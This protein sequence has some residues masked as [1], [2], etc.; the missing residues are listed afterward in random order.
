MSA[1]QLVEELARYQIRTAS[2][3]T[4]TVRFVTHVDVSAADIHRTVQVFSHLVG[5]RNPAQDGNND[6]AAG[7]INV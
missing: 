7:D 6:F 1:D 2:V 3:D 5:R 4:N